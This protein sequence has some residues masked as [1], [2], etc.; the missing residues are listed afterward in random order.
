MD[1]HFLTIYLFELDLH[2]ILILILLPVELAA[3]VITVLHLL[4]QRK[5]HK[6]SAISEKPYQPTFILIILT[7]FSL[8]V[9][10]FAAMVWFNPRPLETIRTYSSLIKTGIV[11]TFLVSLLS[12]IFGTIGGVCLALLIA[13][14]K[15]VI[16]SMLLDSPM[17]SLIYVLLGIPALVL[18]Y[19]TYY[20]GVQSIFW[21]AVIALSI[22]LL[23][24][25]T[26]IITGSIREIGQDQLNSA[27]AF[28]YSPWQVTRYF[29]LG[30][31]IR[32]SLQPLLVQY[33]T[34]IKLSS[35][36]G[37]IG[38]TEIY[39]A[40]QEIIKETQDPATSY[41]VLASAYVIIVTPFA[42]LADYL[43]QKWKPAV[44]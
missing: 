43:E 30:F 15:R 4:S 18:L 8:A 41:F 9:I 21:S 40:S 16:V 35:F 27:I 1:L 19:L 28:G 44:R 39:H 22:N 25:V 5:K 6:R 31:V 14:R 7:L 26:K 34:T 23:P 33:Y 29:K 38:L 32:H 20:S 10:A 3:I 2:S 24:F 17:L 42:I 13:G 36:A 12:I 11:L 37:L